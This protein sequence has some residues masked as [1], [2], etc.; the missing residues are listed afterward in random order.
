M[1]S[2]SD[3]ADC[4]RFERTQGTVDESW[5]TEG[6]EKRGGYVPE[7]RTHSGSAD[8]SNVYR[9]FETLEVDMKRA[10]YQTNF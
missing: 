3:T 9:S 6:E 10:G 8:R 1:A 7:A 5:I 4:Q 2:F